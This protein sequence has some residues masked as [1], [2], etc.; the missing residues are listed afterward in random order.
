[1]MNILPELN[2]IIPMAGLGSR[3]TDYGFS[4]NKYLLPI[5]KKLTKMIEKAILTLNI[6]KNN[7]QFIFILREENGKNKE[8]RELLEKICNENN[9]ICKILSVEK[10]T[11]GPTSTCYIAKD[12][13]DNDIPLIISN[14]DQI[15]EW[16]FE[17]FYEKSMNHDGCVLTY[18]PNYEL[19]IGEKDKHSFVRFDNNGEPVEFVEKTVI[20]NEALVGVHFYKKGRYFVESA[21][22][23]FHNNIRAPNGEFYLSY[24]YQAMIN[25]KYNIGTY[26]LPS[27]D[28]FHP[29]G[30]PEDYFKYYNLNNKF[31]KFNLSQYEKINNNTHY[32][33]CY[34]NKDKTIE[35]NN[36]LIMI[37][38][39]EI[40]NEPQIFLTGNNK[41]CKFKEDTYYIHIFN[42]ES[43]YKQINMNDYTR[44]WLIGDFF[45][46][47]KKIKEYEIALLRHKKDEKWGFHYHKE[48][49]EINILISGKMILNNIT[50]NSNEIFILEKNII[51]CPIFL[52]DCNILCI[53]LPSVID[54]K[55]II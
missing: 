10:L 14:S 49:D 45:P 29:V 42:M 41:I 1:M 43:E 9:Y 18:K 5:D 19:I 24:T 7:C 16:N 6:K 17:S 37:I 20:S 55:Y 15:L 11:E 34:I 54:D 25:L 2:I 44:G 28:F 4:E 30:E 50:I 22:Y 51:A 23:L 36:E 38:K 27:N 52:E 12:S 32:N 33:I 53:K 40:E 47:I 48:A 8:V 21:E 46:S 26:L 39:G 31:V 35:F 13:I 3:F